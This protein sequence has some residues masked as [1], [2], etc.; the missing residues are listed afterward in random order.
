[1][2]P[3]RVRNCLP[4]KHKSG[5]RKP[6]ISVDFMQKYTLNFMKMKEKMKFDMF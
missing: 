6:H 5:L 4:P 3:N 2:D 1:L